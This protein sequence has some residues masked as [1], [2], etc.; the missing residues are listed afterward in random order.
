GNAMLGGLDWDRCLADWLNEQFVAKH[1]VAPSETLDGDQ[2]LLHFAEEV[3]H[4][5]S[6]R[7]KVPIRIPFAR[8][9]L[10]TSVTRELFSDLTAHLTDRTRF[11]M[12]KLM[13]DVGYRWEQIDQVLL[14]GGSTKMRDVR[15]M[16]RRES[17][18]DPNDAVSGEG[19]VSEG[20]ALFAA[21]FPLQCYSNPHA[22]PVSIAQPNIQIGETEIHDVT[23]H[24]LGVLAVETKT[25]RRKKKEVIASQS[26][27]PAK[28]TVR[29]F[30]AREGQP[31]VVVEVIEGGDQRGRYASRIGICT[32][33]RLPASLPEKTPVDV[34]FYC[35]RDGLIRVQASLPT[36]GKSHEVVID[37]DYESGGE[38][39]ERLAELQEK[40]NLQL[41]D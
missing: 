33:D 18:L 28:Q 34:Q 4:S 1:G 30:T 13:R 27:I 39:L 32:V 10:E 7:P 6:R 38:N 22:T 36:I 16:I 23:R 20:A 25:G 40:N 24:S 29:F 21:K 5:L 26:P 37:R 11:T 14:V 12:T 9:T 17:G 31:S 3:K 19:A 8:C 35:D 2:M 15:D 41:A